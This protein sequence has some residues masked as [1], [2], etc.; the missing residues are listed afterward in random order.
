MIPPLDNEFIALIK[1][2]ALVSLLT[3]DDL[4]HE[5]QKIMSVSPPVARRVSRRHVR[6]RP[7]QAGP[8]SLIRCT[9]HTRCWTPI[10]LS[11]DAAIH[12]TPR[13][14]FRSSSH[15]PHHLRAR[16]SPIARRIFF[17]L[18]RIFLIVHYALC[19]AQTHTT[20]RWGCP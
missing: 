1:N 8:K 7:A 2:S 12:V 4:M 14:P 15:R 6:N 11:R 5:G 10:E 19:T 18:R 17:Q 20:Y 13:A 9:A 3:I 16:K